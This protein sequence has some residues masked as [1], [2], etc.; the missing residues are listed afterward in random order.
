MAESLRKESLLTRLTLPIA[1]LFCVSPT[2]GIRNH[3]WAATSPDVVSGMYYEP[4]GVP[5][6]LSASAQDEKL[7]KRL[8]EWTDD[9][10]SAI[11]PLR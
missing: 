10:L 5:G 2:V 6:K 9:A 8:H 4:V 1:P 11:K 3:L 7:L